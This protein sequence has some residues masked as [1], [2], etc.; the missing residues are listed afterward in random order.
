[1]TE[2]ALR[3]FGDVRSIRG[4]VFPAKV[5]F[6]ELIITG[7]PGSGKTSEVQ[8]IG[9]WPEEG[10]LDLGE[11][12]WWRSR[13][14]SFRPREVH[15][16]LPFQGHDRALTLFDEEWRVADPPPRLNLSRVYLPPPGRWQRRYVFEFLLPPAERLYAARRERSYRQSHPVDIEL[17]RE[18]V[19]AQLEAYQA[20]ALHFHRAGLRV[21][22][23]DV[24][25]G[26]PKQFDADTRGGGAPW[27]AGGRPRIP[28][29]ARFLEQLAGTSSA[30]VI[31]RLE[32]V[33]LAGKQVRVPLD[34]LPIEITLGPQRLQ[35]HLE[36]PIDSEKRA[37]GHDVVVFDPDEYV[38][39][40][41]GFVR[42]RP[43]DR[44]RIGKG[45]D[46]RAITPRLPQDILP[47]LD[48]GYDG[49]L[50]SVVDL[51]S[52][53]GTTVG[54]PEDPGDADRLKR[55]TLERLA[56]VRAVYGGELAALSPEDALA[57]LREVNRRLQEQRFR[58]SDG[59]GRPGGLVELPIEVTPV[60]VGDLHANLDNLL[61]VLTANRF[62]DE[63]EEGT[64]AVIVLGD[65]VH[66]EEGDLADMEG[67][68][69]VMDLLLRFIAAFPDHLVYLRG[70][71]DS[72]SRELT[73]QGVPQGRVWEERLRASRGGAY[74]DALA[75]FY[76]R[77]PHVAASADFAACHGGPPLE[78]VTRE[79][80]VDLYRYPRLMHQLEWNRPH[81]ASNPAG[82][83]KREVRALKQALDLRSEHPLVVAHTPES[84]EETIWLDHGGIKGH[85]IVHS[86]RSDKVGLLVRVEGELVPF[87]YP[88]EP[89]SG[90]EA[91][92]R[93]ED[94]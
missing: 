81:R 10:F 12:R 16:G 65:A 32:E 50:I 87:V 41:S 21:F 8:A 70:N 29:F 78:L 86:A 40:I 11:N 20:V 59:R 24:Y 3:E 47:R 74:V 33:H 44:T 77:L 71:H 69:L 31:G 7:P 53:T 89:L 83:T 79:R 88:A 67:S 17:S 57:C 39:G 76:D 2:V 18:Q 28:L 56:R 62:L 51:H 92:T 48:L 80:L 23:R 46:D 9:G 15:L 58:P 35:V 54:A 55:D 37:A 82:Y 84:G 60:I 27:E 42:L 13:T 14:L 63:L 72:F 66:R 49:G 85:H 4:L 25:G 26:P 61:R 36:S 64:A 34:L 94:R 52:P 68:M 45:A 6:R 38:A 22:V 1:M 91:A 5:A 30:P 19:E 73:K 93:L 43:G 90:L 75:D